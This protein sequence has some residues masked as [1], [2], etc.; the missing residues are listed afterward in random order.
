M[1]RYINSKGDPDEH[2]VLQL[3]DFF[4]HKEHL[5]LVCELL[6]DNLFE[7]YKYNR[8][9][10]DELYFTLPRLQR[11]AMQILTGL[12]FIHNLNIIHC[13]LKV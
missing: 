8:D 1:L 3:F 2:H 6:R 12:R 11:I 5:F 13:D 9:S 7:F 4:Y 10:G